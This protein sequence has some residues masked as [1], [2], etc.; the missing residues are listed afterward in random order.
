[1]ESRYA[2]HGHVETGAEPAWKRRIKAVA[3]FPMLIG[4]TISAPGFGRSLEPRVRPPAKAEADPMTDFY[5]PEIGN[6][7]LANCVFLQSSDMLFWDR[8]VLEINQLTHNGESIPV[9]D[10]PEEGGLAKSVYSVR[11]IARSCGSCAALFNMILHCRTI[12]VRGTST[13]KIVSRLG[14]APARNSRPG[15][16]G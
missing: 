9:P 15:Y 10:P 4:S 16:A 2:S 3:E 7:R 12:S 11:A 14:N 5:S 8:L 6:K 13:S 1:M